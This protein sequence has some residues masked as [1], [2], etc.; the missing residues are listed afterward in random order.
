MD[1]DGAPVDPARGLRARVR[2]PGGRLR[3]SALGAVV[4]LLAGAGTA[5]V[6]GVAPPSSDG[7]QDGVPSQVEALSTPSD[8]LPLPSP[9]PSASTPVVAPL[10]EQQTPA[11]L[12]TRSAGLSPA[13]RT[14]VRATE[15]VQQTLVL[16]T[17]PV[18]VAGAVA[19]AVSADPG[20]LRAW[21]PALTARSDALWASIARGDVT[22]S[23]EMGKNLGLELGGPVALSVG[24]SSMSLRLGAFAGTALPGL[25]LTVSPG[26]ARE[27]H[28]TPDAAMLV[29]AA[30][31]TDL[32]ALRATLRDRLGAGVDVQLLQQVP[33]IRDAGSYLTRAQITAAVS[34]ALSKVGRPYVW[35][36]VG[37]DS[38]DCSGL[39]GWAMHAA[40]VTVPRTSEQLWLAGPHLRPEDARA[41]DLLFWS[42]DPSAPQDLDHVALYLGGGQMVSAPHTGDVVHVAPVTA[43]NFRGVVRLDPKAAASVGGAV[44]ALA[45]PT[46]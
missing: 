40:G 37:P 9:T 27:L 34:A 22:A 33:E 38:F 8:A 5:A 10:G 1:S 3:L 14:A 36:A 35:G 11:L 15:S 18:R 28:L 39:I 19:H 7:P 21:T 23:F 17:G 20:S 2:W 30:P 24:T 44:W 43:R 31:G 6:A 41:G 32:L 13:Q 42:N 45:A 12:V 29:A 46:S 26:R 25:D 4:V 16:A